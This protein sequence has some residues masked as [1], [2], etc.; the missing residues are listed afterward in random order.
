M[1]AVDASPAKNDIIIRKTSRFMVFA[2]IRALLN[3]NLGMFDTKKA[4]MQHQSK[5]TIG[6]PGVDSRG[7]TIC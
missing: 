1:T 5:I 2:K 7:S 6:K 3:Q 4:N